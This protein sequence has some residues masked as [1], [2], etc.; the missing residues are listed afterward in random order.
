MIR[1]IDVSAYQSSS[2]DTDSISFVFIKATEGRSYIN[3]KL[4]GMGTTV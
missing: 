3:P 4:A 1:G 2:Y